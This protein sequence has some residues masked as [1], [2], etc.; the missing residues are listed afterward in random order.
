MFYSTAEIPTQSLFF[1]HKFN[2]ANIAFF[3]KQL[4]SDTLI[5]YNTGLANTSAISESPQF[6]TK[7][8]ANY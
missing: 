2:K 5:I 4:L 1:K 7:S 8:N 3:L 6:A